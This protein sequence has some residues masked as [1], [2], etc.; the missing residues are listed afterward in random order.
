M[1]S[2]WH[3]PRGGFGAAGAAQDNAAGRGDEVAQH[4]GRRRGAAGTLAVEHELAGVLGF[5]EDGVECTADSGERVFAGQQRGVDTDGDAGF[6]VLVNQFLGDRQQLDDKA[7]FLGGGDVRR[8][9]RRD[10]LAGDVFQGEPRVE[11]QRGK[12]RGLGG[13][14]VAFD[15]GRGVG[16]RVAQAL[17]L[18]QRVGELRAGGVHLVEDEVGGAVDDAE[19]PG[20]PV[21]GQAVADG[22]QDGDGAGHGGLVGQLHPGLVRFL[23]QGGAVLGQERL[24]AADNTGTVPHGG[25][26]QGPGRLNAAHELDHDVGVLDEDFGVGGEQLLRQLDVALGIEVAHRDAAAVPG[27]RRCARR[28]RRRRQ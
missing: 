13:G 15:V 23:V 28:G 16:F 11:G 17:G 6:A 4:G 12:D 27:G 22:P 14:V 3:V 26:D 7:G 21:A 1:G 24:V 10:A 19:H 8:G 20:D 5:D 25:Q 9:D 2:A 18:G